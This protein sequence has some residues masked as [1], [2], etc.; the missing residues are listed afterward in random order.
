MAPSGPTQPS[1]LRPFP[2]VSS[3]REEDVIR[4]PDLHHLRRPDARVTL[5]AAGAAVL[6]VVVVVAVVRSNGGGGSSHGP[7]SRAGATASPGATSPGT[8]GGGADP[9]VR[10]LVG[11]GCADYAAAV[12]SGPGSIAAMRTEPVTVALAANPLVT[13]LVQGLSGRLNPKTS[14]TQTLDVGDFTVFAPID[15][16]FAKVPA[17]SLQKVTLNPAALR[18]MLSHL[19]VRGQLAPSE[20]VGS[21]LTLAGDSISVTS[22][23][24]QV[25]VGAAQVVC[26]GLRT[27]NATI[28]LVD[29]VPSLRG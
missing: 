17:A 22:T 25:A 14:L 3:R 19:V 5:A 10:G 6:A 24:G 8:P 9:A 4:V 27:A 18:K 21:H 28:Y 23:S 15:S 26:G 7:G 1:H 13:T 12:A 20:V 2:A 16:A 29:A 11:S